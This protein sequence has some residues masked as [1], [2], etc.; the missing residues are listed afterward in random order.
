MEGAQD[1][2]M[3]KK[4]VE[5]RPSSATMYIHEAATKGAILLT[6]S[7]SFGCKNPWV[8]NR[9]CLYKLSIALKPF[10]MSPKKKLTKE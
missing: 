1:E 7:L 6:L 9:T 4:K 5:K 3:K 8:Q 2:K 10:F